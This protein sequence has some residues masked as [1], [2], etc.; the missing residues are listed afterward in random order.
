MRGAKGEQ[1]DMR[2]SCLH[3]S[4]HPAFWESR[5]R[6]LPR[7][8]NFSQTSMPSNH[9]L[10]RFI[11]ME[12]LIA[13]KNP[14]LYSIFTYA[15]QGYQLAQP[16]KHRRHSSPRQS[17]LY[18]FFCASTHASCSFFCLSQSFCSFFFRLFAISSPSLSF[19][20]SP[21]SSQALNSGN[22]NISL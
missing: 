8:A 3:W 15:N 18:Y 13:Q 1:C 12:R 20:G 10:H 19:V 5:I 21:S 22:R 4:R 2:T 17:M 16:P 9:R 14:V 11:E 6:T 7:Q